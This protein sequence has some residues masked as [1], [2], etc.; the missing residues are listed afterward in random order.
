MRVL[1]FEA[2]D[3]SSS[4]GSRGTLGGPFNILKSTRV[5]QPWF[6]TCDLEDQP[7]RLPHG[8]VENEI[9]YASC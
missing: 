7:L 5:P 9:R 2:E 1:L 4:T 6:F 3:L 8:V